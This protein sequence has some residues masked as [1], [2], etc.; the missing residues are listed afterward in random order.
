MLT[1]SRV[2]SYV[3]LAGCLEGESVRNNTDLIDS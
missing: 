3:L 2:Y 1:L